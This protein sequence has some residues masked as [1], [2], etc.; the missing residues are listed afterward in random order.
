MRWLAGAGLF[1]LVGCN[2]IFGLS[3]TQAFDAGVD[4]ATVQHVTLDWQ[5]GTLAN[6]S[7]APPTYTP[8]SPAPKVRLASMTGPFADATYAADGTITIPHDLLAAP[9]RLE[10]T[11]ADGVVHEVQ[12]KPSDGAH[13]TVPIFGRLNRDPV[14]TS[15]GY[16]ITAN[17]S[18]TSFASPHVFTLGLWT[19][20]T[21]PAPSGNP[22]DY[23]FASALSFSGALGNPNAAGDRGLVI[24]Y[25][26]QANCQVATG[27]ADFSSTLQAGGNA[28]QGDWG[29]SLVSIAGAIIPQSAGDRLNGSKGLAS[30]LQSATMLM[31]GAG[32]STMMPG[33]TTTDAKVLQLHN[34]Q[35]PI[36]VMITLLQCPISGVPA[37]T[38]PSQPAYL[39]EFPTILHAQAVGIRSI[40]VPD[41]GGATS[42][43][44]N[45][46]SGLETVLT[47]GNNSF[48]IS[49]PA[50]L[51][52]NILLTSA[53]NAKSPLDGA[54][55]QVDIGSA[56]GVF[57]LSFTPEPGL[58][59]DYYDIVLH[60][61]S[62][63]AIPT[64]RI[65]TVP[66]P[67]DGSTEIDVMIDGANFTVGNNY[68]FEIRSFVGHPQAPHGD[69]STVAYPYGSAL[70]FSRTFKATSP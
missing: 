1:A 33:L 14:P 16:T 62:N 34:A 20:G 29:S 3:A 57:K 18:P 46:V 59:A 47:S 9:W 4:A 68:V 63:N 31:Y 22:I 35:L 44:V 58:Q 19:E 2:Q 5:I 11:L 45:L 70:L 26:S 54:T 53:A 55:E 60:G 56:T 38:H 43:S 17:H 6:G 61:I 50:P 67:T 48:S 39:T 36:P 40:N 27:A 28:V 13:I 52:Q 30:Y 41:P 66:A 8:I 10:Y 65:F 24:D 69:F 64:Q 37:N 42:S 15:A 21:A 12:W 23:S 32:A 49:F 7:P 25:G 51:A